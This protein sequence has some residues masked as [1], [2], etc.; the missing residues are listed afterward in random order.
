MLRLATLLLALAALLASAASAGPKY[1]VSGPE[2]VSVGERVRFVAR[3]LKP[4]E[5]L[6]VSLVPTLNRGGNCCGIDP[7]RHATADSS[8]KAVLR[9][10]WP[11]YYFNGDEKVSWR[12]GAKADVIVLSESGR[13]VRVVRV[14]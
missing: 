7:I 10:R 6:Q 11:A 3:G 9:F 1:R 14:R 8:G 12:E 5:H 13:G 4:H 2:R